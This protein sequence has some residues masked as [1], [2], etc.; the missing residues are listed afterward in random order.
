MVVRAALRAPALGL[1]ALIG[2]GVLIPHRHGYDFFDIRLVLAYAFVPMLFV[3]PAVTSLLAP[4]SAARSS[5]ESLYG[6]V[7]ATA[8]YGW[9]ISFAVLGLALVTVNWGQPAGAWQF[10]ALH[11][12]GAYA[13]FSGVAVVFVAAIS[14]YVT[15]LFSVGVARN[16][17]RVGFLA[18][19]LGFYGGSRFLPLSWQ[20]AMGADMTHDAYRRSAMLASLV[21][22]LFTAGLLNALR[23]AFEPGE[24][25][26]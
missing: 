5:L 21:L 26:P 11:V 13:G 19:L 10:P 23:A 25:A 7:V 22:L 15:L 20:V 24:Q 16:V 2:F 9:C 17:L 4:G 18:L 6:A 3:A 8:L 12:L 1:G 14:A